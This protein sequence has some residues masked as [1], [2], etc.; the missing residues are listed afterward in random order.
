MTTAEEMADEFR[1]HYCS[2]RTWDFCVNQLIR[3][4]LDEIERLK[5]ELASKPNRH[6]EL[7]MSETP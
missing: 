5:A 2:G 6:T 3:P 1:N 4:L 7:W